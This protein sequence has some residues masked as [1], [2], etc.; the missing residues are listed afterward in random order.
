MAIAF[1]YHKDMKQNSVM[2]THNTLPL[3]TI[4]ALITTS[5]PNYNFYNTQFPICFGMK[6][7]QNIFL[8]KLYIC[9]VK[10]GKEESPTKDY[11]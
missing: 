8:N 9:L 1:V 6:L 5:S 2:L 11:G 3:L 4:L 7:S 10:T